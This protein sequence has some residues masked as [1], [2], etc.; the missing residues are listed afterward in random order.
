MFNVADLQPAPAPDRRCR[1]VKV[2]GYRCRSHAKPNSDLCVDH[3]HKKN[4]TRGRIR[5]NPPATFNTVPLVRFAWAD[6]HDSILFNCN[7]IALALVHDT[8][9]A[10]TAGALNALMHTAQRSLHQKFVHERFEA[11][12]RER[13]AGQAPSPSAAQPSSTPDPSDFV[14]D[15][16]LDVDGMPLALPDEPLQNVSSPAQL[17]T[18]PVTRNLQPETSGPGAPSLSSPAVGDDK[19]G[20]DPSVVRCPL[21]P[22]IPAP[23]L[24]TSEPKP[25]KIDP[26][27]PDTWDEATIARRRE[28]LLYLREYYKDNPKMLAEIETDPA[29]RFAPKLKYE[30]AAEPITLPSLSASAARPISWRSQI[31]AQ[32]QRGESHGLQAV[33]QGASLR[34]ASARALPS[35]SA[36]RPT[37]RRTQIAAQRQ[38]GESHGLQAVEQGASLRRASAPGPQRRFLS[39]IPYTL[40]PIPSITYPQPQSLP[41]IAGEAPSKCPVSHT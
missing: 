26:H 27:D 28:N 29:A 30:P 40:S 15:Y 20:E 41:H 5:P 34:R 16:V 37:S 10:R 13:A 14:T 25:R 11:R 35:A 36:E 9:S 38:R 12:E 8:I 18:L 39:P 4:Y 19:V 32:R 6:D 22:P 17:E 31:A 3:D 1:F 33:E 24:L 7:Q 2:N 21:S 23:T